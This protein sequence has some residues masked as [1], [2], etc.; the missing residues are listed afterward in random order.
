MA[1]AT[2]GGDGGGGRRL[3][4]FFLPF[5]ARGHLI[6]MTDLACRMAAASPEVVETTMVVTPANATVVASTVAHAGAASAE[7]AVRV[8]CYPFPDVGLERGVECL[9]SAAAH[10]AWRVYRAVDLSQPVHESLL[11]QHRPDAIVADVPFWWATDIAAELGVPRLTFNPVG[12]FPQLAMNNLVTIRPD[13]VRRGLAGPPVSVPS[14]PGKEITIPVS[15]LPDFLVQ[16][17]HLSMCWDRIKASQLAGFGVVVNTFADLERPYCDEFSR[18]DARRAYFVGPL[19]L[20]SH[21]AVHRGGDGD[22]DCLTWLSTKPSQSVVY[23]CF[24]S[25]AHFSAT[26]TRELALGLEA[27]NQ[28]FLW[29]IRSEDSNGGGRWAPEGWE[30]RVAGRGFVVRGWAPQL[31]VLAHPSVGAFLMHCGWNSL[32][33]AA[34]AGV[35]VLTWPLVFEQFINE[36]LVTDVAAF[37]ARVWGGGKRS[38]REHESE[39]VPAEA[40][41][42]AVAGFMQGGGRRDT[43]R[44]RARELAGSARAAVSENG[45]SWSDIRRLIQ[46]LTDT[47]ASRV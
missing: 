1:V 45:S 34:A 42:T 6:P 20:P 31:A 11:R 10:D 21:S 24:G 17:E 46:D 39:T 41:A 15:E 32:L 23:V 18:V 19:S 25:W 47:S 36:R 9:G 33:E 27:S 2:A 40:I 30:Q 22:V 26:Q 37:G 13:I 16:D 5:F 29:V 4:V 12:V 14:L 7:Q 28:P 43:A 44:S 8:V 35:P 38:V 3:R